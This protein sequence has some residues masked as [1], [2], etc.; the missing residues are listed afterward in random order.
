MANLTP[1]PVAPR[2]LSE[3]TARMVARHRRFYRQS[4]SR[5][6]A[7]WSALPRRHYSRPRARVCG[8]LS[9][10]SP[11]VVAREVAQRAIHHDQTGEEIDAAGEPHQPAHA[12]VPPHH[13]AEEGSETGDRGAEQIQYADGGGAHG[14]GHHIEGGSRLVPRDPSGKET[15]SD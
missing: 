5:H 2:R 12:D 7:E 11:A 9:L 4:R 8:V 14:R 3:R 6:G 1:I 15:E 13:A 10:L